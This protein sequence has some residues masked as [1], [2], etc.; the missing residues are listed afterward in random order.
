[1]IVRSH[2]WL[3]CALVLGASGLTL[4][5]GCEPSPLGEAEPLLVTQE[6]DIKIA[7]SL[8]TQALVFNG[9]STNARAN[10]LVRQSAL[11]ALFSSTTVDGDFIRNQLVDPSARQFMK[12]LASCALSS[13]QSLPWQS[14][15][16][17]SGVW[18]GG[19]G[20]CTQWLNS[21]PT[22]A[23]LMQVSSCILARNNAVN[24]RVELS[25]R[26]K[27]LDGTAFSLQAQ[28]P[29]VAYDP[30]VPASDVP[31]ASFQ[32]CSGATMGVQRNCGWSQDYIGSCTPGAWVRLG[33]G[34]QAVGADGSCHSSAIGS[35]TG[36]QAMLRVCSGIVGCDNEGPRFL[37]QSSGNCN[38]ASEQRP[39]VSFSC[40]V[41]G[42]FNVM[43][44]PWDSS[45]DL[46]TVSVAVG[47]EQPPM[48]TGRYPVPEKAAFP[49]REGAF[50]GNLFT[51]GVA[52]EV[53]VIP[54]RAGGDGTQLI[55]RPLVAGSVYPKMYVCPDPE[56]TEAAAY[57]THRVCSLPNQSSNCAATVV[58][59]C[60]T[61]CSTS[62]APPVAGDGDYGSCQGPL[63][64]G[65][66]TEPVTVFLNGP[67]DVMPGGMSGLCHR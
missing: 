26:G 55:S 64:S 62:D 63:Q 57:A 3:L 45:Q 58:G 7:N 53:T 22:P 11:G 15:G 35:S 60:D 65:T 2:S 5:E 32:P 38:P 24:R 49:F 40:P 46:G 6:S 12:Y 18:A 34:G 23:C 31:L 16:G 9:I 10:L 28:P 33:A 50:Y 41:G 54:S 27:S 1:M 44:A 37:A 51:D 4:L 30:D 14:S 39:A 29:S 43:K 47:L 36:S 20:L 59:S 13:T 19:A 48:P 67:C 66:W 56:W 25:L 8:S 17:H 42:F 21:P 61:V 52:S